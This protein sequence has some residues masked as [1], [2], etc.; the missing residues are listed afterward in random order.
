LGPQAAELP[1]ICDQDLVTGGAEPLWDE[2]MSEPD[3]GAPPRQAIQNP[4]PPVTRLLSAGIEAAIEPFASP[5]ALA[6]GKVNLIAMDAVVARF[7]ARW[8]MRREHVHEHVDGVLDRHLGARGYYLRIS[9][10]D[11]L[12]CQPELGRL[13]GQAV[14]LR[15][16]R[17]ILSHF[18]GAAE[19][20]H[21]TVHE[22]L[23]LSPSCVEAQPVDPAAV[24]RATT[25]T[26]GP[27]G[28]ADHT[29]ELVPNARGPMA[30]SILA[31]VAVWT[32]FVSTSGRKI[33]VV[34]TLDPVMELRG[35]TLIALRLRREVWES[36]SGRKITDAEIARF[37]RSDRLRIDL[38]NLAL[39]I[40]QLRR[41]PPSPPPPALIV[42]AS[43][44]SLGNLDDRARVVHAFN[45]AR[46]FA[47]KG[48][49]CALREIDGVPA[50]TLQVAAAMIAPHSLLVIGH[51]TQ[52]DRAAAR[53]LKDAGF[54]GISAD[55][56]ANLGDGALVGWTRQAIATAKQASRAVILYG[57][58]SARHAQLAATLGAT[59]AHW[60]TAKQGASA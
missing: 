17:E 50:T 3:W 25:E 16:L 45:E 1:A 36:G 21:V 7:G 54:K 12:V 58:P 51:V 19:V 33:E 52:F 42:P 30:D 27:I 59:H 32:P 9:D 28:T 38:A 26:P 24:A 5:G 34:C 11:I 44:S 6:A 46:T 18:L 20:R 53:V 22:V 40:D 39:G 41:E 48:L 8:P 10:T 2:C 13:V 55:C 43:F 60:N 29:L 4:G 31:P 56:P 49:I 15:I 47:G 37:P 23:R 57:L 14:C 35:R